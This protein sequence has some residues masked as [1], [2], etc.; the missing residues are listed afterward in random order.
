MVSEA[1]GQF[2]LSMLFKFSLNS[3]FATQAKFMSSS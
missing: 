2:K 3:L 1:L